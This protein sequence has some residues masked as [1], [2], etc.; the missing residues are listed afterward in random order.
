MSWARYPSRI[1]SDYFE[2]F[3][4]LYIGRD[5]D[6]WSSVI[7]FDGSYF[8][9]DY[10]QVP[11]GTALFS[12]TV[13]GIVLE[14]QP[15]LING[16]PWWKSSVAVLYADF[17]GWIYSESLEAGFPPIEYFDVEWKG[18]A[19]YFSQT[20]PQ[21]FGATQTFVG[22]GSLRTTGDTHTITV[23]M[24]S[25]PRW[26]SVSDSEI[27]RYVAAGGATGVRDVG[28]PVWRV[29]ISTADNLVRADVA[30]AGGRYAYY[31]RGALVEWNTTASAY[32]FGEYDSP[33]GWWQAPAAPVPG[34]GWTLV[35]TFPPEAD[36]IPD[37][38]NITL[39][40]LEWQRGTGRVSERVYFSDMARTI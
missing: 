35:F 8:V 20:I 21:A 17:G 11:G 29:G 14:L 37:G 27:G 34:A 31:F 28:N 3:S 18:D 22:G 32:V 23:E 6:A 2:S 13:G 36:P 1:F 4:V 30:D 38:D 10:A 24:V 16:N 26:E 40:W 15:T 19:F 25:P 7:Q 33:G 5:A 39:A 9:V 12:V